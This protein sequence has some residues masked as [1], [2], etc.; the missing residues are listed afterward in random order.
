MCLTLKDIR[1]QRRYRQRRKQDILKM[2]ATMGALETK[3]QF[4]E[5]QID[6]YNQYIKTCLDNLQA[7]VSLF[8]DSLVL[9][10]SSENDC[11]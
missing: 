1:N 4:Y 2:K 5:E 10:L 8:A 7:K 11:I 3:S 9:S 6:Y